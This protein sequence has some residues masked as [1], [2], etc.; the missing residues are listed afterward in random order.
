MRKTVTRLTTHII[1]KYYAHKNI[2]IKYEHI[3]MKLYTLHYRA[4]FIRWETCANLARYS[5]GGRL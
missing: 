3:H 1:R 5:V 4:R 2:A